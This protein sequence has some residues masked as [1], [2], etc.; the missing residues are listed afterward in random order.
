MQFAALESFR[1]G[2]PA[3]I[4]LVLVM[5][6]FVWNISSWMGIQVTL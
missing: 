4:L 5:A 1:A 2:I 6:V 3:S